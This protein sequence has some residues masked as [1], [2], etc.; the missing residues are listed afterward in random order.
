[1]LGFVG[2]MKVPVLTK[3]QYTVATVFIDHFS[4]LSFIHLQYSTWGSSTS[5]STTVNLQTTC[6]GMIVHK[7]NKHGHF[8]ESTHTGSM[9]SLNPTFKCIRR[10]LKWCCFMQS[11][12]G[13]K[14]SRLTCGHTPFEWQVTSCTT[15]LGKMEKSRSIGSQKVSLDLALKQGKGYSKWKLTERAWVWLYLGT[16]PQHA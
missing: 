6:F 7:N 10:W 8:A 5:T 1:M 9:A 11:A 13:R 15:H 3:H 4:W 2:Q 16:S 12:D 14:L